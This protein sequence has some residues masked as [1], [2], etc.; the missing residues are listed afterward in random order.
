MEIDDDTLW[1]TRE[2]LDEFYDKQLQTS[3]AMNKTLME[4]CLVLLEQLKQY[5]QKECYAKISI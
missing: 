2:E 3:I 4:L 1:M 5:E